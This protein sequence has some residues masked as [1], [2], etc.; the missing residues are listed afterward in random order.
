[1]N[2]FISTTEAAKILGISRVAVFNK[3]KS[4]DIKAI[5]V[6]RNYIIHRDDIMN[7]TKKGE[8]SSKD[9]EEID[10]EVSRVVKQYGETLKLLKDN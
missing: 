2:D 7:I 3:I 10:K 6:G 9:M 4:G 5:K 1:M 8:I